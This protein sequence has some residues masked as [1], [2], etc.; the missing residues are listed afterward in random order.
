VSRVVSQGVP[1]SS[2]PSACD[3]VTGPP[4]GCCLQRGLNLPVS[5]GLPGATP[6]PRSTL[7]SSISPPL[8]GRPAEPAA[9]A[10]RPSAASCG[11]AVGPCSSHSC[12]E[13]G[14]ASS[15]IPA[16]DLRMGVP[17]PPPL[18]PLHL[19]FAL[20][21]DPGDASSDSST[22]SSP[23][24]SPRRAPS[25]DGDDGAPQPPARSSQRL[26]AGGAAAGRPSPRNPHGLSMSQRVA[27]LQWRPG[28]SSCRAPIFVDTNDPK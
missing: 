24:A 14:A 6:A 27:A 4:G 3:N 16:G 12:S 21:R 9:F 25:E 7:P 13:V 26:S 23:R 18:D 8:P 2:N 10:F 22:T 28:Q 15:G 1:G 17:H 11:V 19:A 20:P 5:Y